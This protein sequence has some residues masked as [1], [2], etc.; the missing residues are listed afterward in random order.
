MI[1]FNAF[2][3]ADAFQVFEAERDLKAKKS[4]RNL[5]LRALKAADRAAATR[6][7]TVIVGKP[8]HLAG[9]HKL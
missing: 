1:E 9:V 8:S 7:R 5:E 4:A 3:A 6:E 2:V